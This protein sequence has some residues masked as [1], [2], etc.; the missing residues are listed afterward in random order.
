MHCIA[1]VF[2]LIS[3]DTALTNA[4]HTLMCTHRYTP[5][6]MHCI[7][8]VFGPVSPDTARTNALQIPY[9]LFFLLL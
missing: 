7:A 9:Y 4:P 5:E 8:V 3:P 6:H 1:A 2:G